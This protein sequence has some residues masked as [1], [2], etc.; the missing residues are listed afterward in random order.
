M[1]TNEFN[2]LHDTWPTEIES[3]RRVLADTV[4]EVGRLTRQ[5]EELAAALKAFIN[6]AAKV[7]GFPD[8]YQ[9]YLA[10]LVVARAALAKLEKKEEV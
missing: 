7:S 5:R 8:L 4:A 1:E 6:D 3:L 2:R 9:P 10:S